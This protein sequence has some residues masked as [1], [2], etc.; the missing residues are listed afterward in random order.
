MGVAG[1]HDDGTRPAAASPPRPWRAEAGQP[2]APVAPL[3]DG[4]DAHDGAFRPAAAGYGNTAH[5][6]PSAVHPPPSIVDRIKGASALSYRK[7]ALTPCSG[8]VEIVEGK[9]T[10]DPSKVAEGEARKVCLYPTVANQY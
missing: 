6:A 9:L 10:S 4:D 2:G 7:H 5:I 1:S 8:Q 3:G